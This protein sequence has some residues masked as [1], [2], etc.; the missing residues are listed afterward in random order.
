MNPAIFARITK[1][2]EAKR[3]VWGRAAEEVPDLS[4]EIFDYK[5]SKPYFQAWS[6]KF[7]NA[8]DGKS[9]GNIRA[10]HGNVAA[11]KAIAV[12][13]N[14]T[15]RAI[16]IG[17]KVVDENE[18]A[19]V[20]EGVYT[21][22]SIG[23]K[24]IGDKTTEKID[25]KDVRRYTADPIEISLVDAPCIPTCKY[26]DIV[27]ADGSTLQK[28]F[29][30]AA[31]EAKDAAAVDGAAKV[32]GTAPAKTDDTEI[33]VE[34]TGTDDEVVALGEAMKAGGFT[35]ADTVKLV[36]DAA[37]AKNAKPVEPVALKIADAVGVKKGM[38]N[39]GRFAELLEGL[40]GVAMSAQYDMEAEGDASPVP[41][42]M[43]GWL[44]DG[45][46]MFVAMADEESG[47]LVASLKAGPGGAMIPIMAAAR[48]AGVAKALADPKLTLGALLKIAAEYDVDV[49]TVD[50][51]ITEAD[52]GA[53]PVAKLRAA[54]VEKAGARHSAAD[55]DR[56]QAAHDHLAALGADCSGKKAEPTGA[57]AKVEEPTGDVAKQLAD[58]LNRIK[59]LEAQPMP[60]PTVQIKTV[61][62]TQDTAPGLDAGAVVFE[63]EDLILDKN[64]DVDKAASAIKFSHR[65]GGRPAHPA[66]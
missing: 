33:V 57:V 24:Y 14:D 53:D 56:L 44:A 9:L 35:L 60:R 32:D 59:A 52:A 58:A 12:D 51:M 38:W 29:K 64:G 63:A 17:T 23:G 1:V 43:R 62:K 46:K 49:D 3:E 50:A 10:M 16:D 6:Q 42:A 45:V 5:S 66:R 34:V 37:T 27:K 26:F 19:K 2:D 7:A 25:G 22:F 28:L 30:G 20:L 36:N 47:E 54:I 11:G 55:K 65:L 4:G 48:V 40:A 39:V 21:G 41:A 8:T 61:T 13:F 18:W 15:A 31:P